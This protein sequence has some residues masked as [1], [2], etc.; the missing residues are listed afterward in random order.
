MTRSLP[1]IPRY[2]P[3]TRAPK[4]KKKEFW[5]VNNNTVEMALMPDIVYSE[6]YNPYPMKLHPTYQEALNELLQ[7]QEHYGLL[8]NNPLIEEK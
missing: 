3:T 1:F 5:F 4:T 8:M 6:E 2:N 7:L